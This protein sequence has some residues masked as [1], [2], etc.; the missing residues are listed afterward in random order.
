MIQTIKTMS[1]AQ[2]EA[3]IDILVLCACLFFML[4]YATKVL[5]TPEP[6]PMQKMIG[7]HDHMRSAEVR[8]IWRQVYC[9]CEKLKLSSPV[10]PMDSKK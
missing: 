1:K 10:Q 9:E 6:T 2:K 5:L 3:V 7:I 4:G 8:Y